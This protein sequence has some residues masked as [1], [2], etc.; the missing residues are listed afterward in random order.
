M[1]RAECF[2]P[3]YQQTF[4]PANFFLEE[5]EQSLAD[6]VRLKKVALESLFEQGILVRP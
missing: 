6:E 1:I 4:V 5:P 3:L 2:A